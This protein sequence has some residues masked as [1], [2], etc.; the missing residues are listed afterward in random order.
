MPEKNPGFSKTVSSKEL[1]LSSWLNDYQPQSRKLQS[2]QLR[3]TFQ[4]LHGEVIV[5]LLQCDLTTSKIILFMQTKE[6]AR[7][8][9]LLIHGGGQCHSTSPVCCCHPPH[10]VMPSPLAEYLLC[11]LWRWWP[12]T[13][14][15]ETGNYKCTNT[16]AKS[17][18]H[19]DL[20]SYSRSDFQWDSK[21]STSYINI[22][23]G[24]QY[25]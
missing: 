7:S 22:Q 11:P 18:I 20:E 15:Q 21:A 8:T 16:Q 9:M 14:E 5:L 13:S 24:S 25:S 6:I 3:C 17:G 23:L 1:T 4:L 10:T 12:G 19:K 2:L